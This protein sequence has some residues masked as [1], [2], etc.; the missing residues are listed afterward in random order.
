MKKL[1]IT[2]IV[3]MFCILMILNTNQAKAQYDDIADFLKSGTEDAETLFEAYLTP[4]ANALGTNLS[5]GWYNTAKPHATLGFDVTFTLNTTF[6]SSGERE[7]LFDEL[8]LKNIE[9][10]N[11]AD[12]EVPTAASSEDGV[13]MQTKETLPDGKPV[14][15]FRSPP[16]TKI[17]LMPSP[18]IQAG[19]GIP[20]DTE[21]TL[22]YWPSLKIKNIQLGLWGVGIKHG[23]K[24]WIPVIKRIPVLHLTLQAGYTKLT[25]SANLSFGPDNFNDVIF[26]V[27]ETLFDDQS[28]DLEMSSF[29]GNLLV[30]ANL[31]VICFYGGVGFVSTKT[32]LGLKGYYPVDVTPYQKDNGSYGTKVLMD[33]IEKDPI[34]MDFSTEVADKMIPRL[35]VGMRLKLGVITIHADYT[36]AT[37]ST[38]TAGFGVSLR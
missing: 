25:S 13:R 3:K 7:F 16:G 2:S 34:D 23:L 4:Y 36:Y 17:P 8:D 38:V 5:A 19:I 32:N 30:G 18:M 37:Y 1:F 29:T 20:Y 12:N 27:D 28:I 31:P 35:N 24:Q 14:L 15:A 33:D 11:P 10:E 22:R 9:L 6:V 26:E 21:I